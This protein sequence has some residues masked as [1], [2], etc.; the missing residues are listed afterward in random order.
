LST[1]KAL[2]KQASANTWVNEGYEDDYEG[3]D[4]VLIA[5]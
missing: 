4:L 5:G 1:A 2:G 3:L